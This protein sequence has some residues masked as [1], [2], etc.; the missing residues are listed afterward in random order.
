VGN[1]IEIK[2]S[3]E[4][5]E[6]L[7]ELVKSAPSSDG[8]FGFATDINRLA[9]IQAIDFGLTTNSRRPRNCENCGNPLQISGYGKPPKFCSDA[10]KQAAYRERRTSQR[11]A[12]AL[13][14]RDRVIEG[15]EKPTSG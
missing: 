4:V 2:V 13:S 5:A 6:W 9:A 3:R 14:A 12:S 7:S 15:K 11:K 10:C 1:Q 8:V